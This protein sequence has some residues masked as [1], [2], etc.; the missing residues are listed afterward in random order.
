MPV[1]G[2]LWDQQKRSTAHTGA[3]SLPLPCISLVPVVPAGSAKGWIWPHLATSG[4]CMC[5]C[6]QKGVLTP[7][8]PTP[9]P[10]PTLVHTWAH[11]DQETRWG[12]HF[13]FTQFLL[14]CFSYSKVLPEQHQEHNTHGQCAGFNPLCKG[15]PHPSPVTGLSAHTSL[16][17]TPALTMSSHSITTLIRKKFKLLA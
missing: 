16:P 15:I 13:F 3:T 6:R 9:I 14:R 4:R 5:W 8:Q 10:F 11:G 7:A 2:K 17:A 1:L 12:F